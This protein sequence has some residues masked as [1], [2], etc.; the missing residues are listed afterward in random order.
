MIRL[1]HPN[2]LD[3][4][5]LA[6]PTMAPD[7]SIGPAPETPP[8]FGKHLILDLSGCN[9]RILNGRDIAL[10]AAQCVELLDMQAYGSAW[11]QHFGHASPATSGHT[12]F[13]PI[14]T[15][16]IT[17]H[18]VDGKHTA[19]LDV[20]SCREFDDDAAV[21]HAEHFFG[22]DPARTVVTVFYR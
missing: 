7:L 15:S 5:P 17:G 11:V 19:H 9:D 10:Y 12:L 1:T 14:E 6:G 21:N 20:F 22:A 3:H 13:Q 8:P 18:F 4:L 2:L 16:A